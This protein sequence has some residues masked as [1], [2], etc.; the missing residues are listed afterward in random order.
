[1]NSSGLPP[2]KDTAAWSTALGTWR[3]RVDCAWGVRLVAAM[4]QARITR[5]MTALAWRAIGRL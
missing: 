1:M 5:E 4:T 3:R 2:G